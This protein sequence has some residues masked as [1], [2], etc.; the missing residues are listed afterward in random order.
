MINNTFKVELKGNIKCNLNVDRCKFIKFANQSFILSACYHLNK[1]TNTK[2]GSLNLNKINDPLVNV[3]TT[4]I[5]LNYGI[6]D[7][8][9]F[10]KENNLIIVTANSNDTFSFIKL[11]EKDE[12]NFDF[13]LKKNVEFGSK[14]SDTCNIVENSND[15]NTLLFGLNDGTVKAY[16]YNKESFVT[17]INLRYFHKK[18]MNMQSGLLSQLKM[19]FF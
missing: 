4:I 6:L 17:N 8:K 18:S 1:L 7:L 19:K 12:D 13:S 14:K 3:E 11:S 15:S 5:D 9:L 2:I 16:D 10:I